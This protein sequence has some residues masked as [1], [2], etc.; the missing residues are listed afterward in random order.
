MADVARRCGLPVVLV[1]AAGLGTLNSTALSLEAMQLRGL[2]LHGL[3]VGAWP[4]AAGLA[5]RCNLVD[6]PALAGQP[7][8]GV[9][10]D[11][12][13]QLSRPDFLGL[14]RRALAP[15]LGGVFDPS[16]FEAQALV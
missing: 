1:T 5:E 15:V 3:V 7:L 9:L 13:A 14:A 16:V 6:L 4:Q 11:Q 10:P 12:A 8:T 2:Q